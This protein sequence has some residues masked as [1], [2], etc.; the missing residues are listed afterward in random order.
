V[1]QVVCLMCAYM[2]S[3]FLSIGLLIFS[4]EIVSCPQFSN[5]EYELVSLHPEHFLPHGAI[6]P[7]YDPATRTWKNYVAPCDRRLR[8]SVEPDSACLPPFRRDLQ[9]RHQ[10]DRVN[11]FLVAINA[12]IKFRRYFKMIKQ[13]PPTTPLPDDVLALMRRVIELIELIYWEPAPTKGSAGE[14]L[15]A[16][17]ASLK[18]KYP[19]R[20]A[21]PSQPRYTDTTPGEESPP[22]LTQASKLSKRSRRVNW[23]AF[24]SLE[25]RM[26][27]GNALVSG[28][29]IPSLPFAFAICEY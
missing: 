9:N 10:T 1:H 20:A 12:E 14:A 4:L 24:A 28:H 13:D 16:E 23:L 5:P 18:R 25:E 3:Q 7:I 8:E 29:G 22:T 2:L 6:L 26:A 11:I 27:Y 19:E 17:R 21:K 15:L